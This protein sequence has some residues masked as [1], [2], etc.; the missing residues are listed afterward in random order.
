MKI[1]GL[2]GGITWHSTLE[3]YRIINEAINLKLGDN[4]SPPLLL[5]SLNF[6]QIKSMQEK[7]DWQGIVDL[8][9]QTALNLERGGADFLVICANTLHRVIPQLQAKIS[10]PVVHI[11]DSLMLQVEKTDYKKLGLLAT[12]YTINS[13]F[14]NDKFRKN[15]DLEIIYPNEKNCKIVDSII[16]DELARGIKRESSMDLLGQIVQQL[17]EDG[18]DAVIAGCTEVSLLIKPSNC[19]LPLF[20]TTL[21]HA[22]TVANYILK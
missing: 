14:Y 1:A 7:D 6:S 9:I 16:Y 5:S 11:V 17:Q 4:V 19:I 20:D 13:D 15:Q 22:A 12:S 10:I 3:Y 2:I 8:M 18:A 21:I